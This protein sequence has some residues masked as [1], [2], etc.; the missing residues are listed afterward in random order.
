MEQYRSIKSKH[1]GEVLFFRLGDFYE[2]FD[3]DAVEVSRL[4]N[5]TL[6][7][8]GDSPMCGVPHHASKLYIA[9]LLRL[10]KK[11]A[12]CE[13]ISLPKGGKGLA[14]RKVIEIITPGT[15]LEEEYLDQGNHNFLAAV[16]LIKKMISWAYIDISTGDFFATTWK[17]SDTYSELEKELGRIKPRELVVS[18]KLFENKKV[19]QI[20]QESSNISISCEDDWH[21]NFENSVQALTKQFGTVN[22][23]AFGVTDHS[24]EVVAAG[25]LLEYVSKN[26]V[27][28]GSTNILPQVTSL[29]IYSD[30]DYVVIDD[31]SRR[32]L[33]LTSNL[34]DGTIHYSL[35][36]CVEF[37]KTAMGKRMLRSFFIHPLKNIEQI[38]KRQNHVAL[39]FQNTRV[40]DAIR[41]EL[42]KILF[43]Y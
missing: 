9:R 5:L 26:T 25:Y 17:D 30:S 24:F 12:I 3:E 35:L 10:G 13:Q 36:E 15:V 29:S 40:L 11:I 39:F 8:R 19:Q 31:S 18:K 20:I 14:D 37:T 32:N 33:E 43:R 2:M 6:T 34:R 41:D 1:L 16:C 22:L 21:F 4:L 27:Y 42:S 28:S 38:Q 7:H 23:H